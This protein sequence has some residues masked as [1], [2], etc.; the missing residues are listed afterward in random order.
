MDVPKFVQLSLTYD[1]GNTW[2]IA[3]VISTE[4]WCGDYKSFQDILGG[5]CQTVYSI[6]KHMDKNLVTL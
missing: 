4:P 6:Q 5:V 2:T 3:D 1:E